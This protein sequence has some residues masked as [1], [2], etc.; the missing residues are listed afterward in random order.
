M[1]GILID[2]ANLPLILIDVLV[3]FTGPILVGNSDIL[4]IDGIV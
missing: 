3:N 4:V 1:V 2:L